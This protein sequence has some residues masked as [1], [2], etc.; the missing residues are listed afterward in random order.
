[1]H[2]SELEE[3][4]AGPQREQVLAELAERLAQTEKRLAL[5][6]RQGLEPDTYRQWQTCH[7]AVRAALGEIRALRD[8]P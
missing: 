2:L 6:L 8:Q 5:T 1:M 4:L 3:R 7:D